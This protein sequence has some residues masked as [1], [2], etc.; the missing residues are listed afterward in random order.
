MTRRCARATASK[1]RSAIP[2]RPRPNTD[3]NCL[4]LWSPA[5]MTL[6][7]HGHWHHGLHVRVISRDSNGI[8]R[9]PSAQRAGTCTPADPPPLRRLDGCR[10]RREGR[11]RGIALTGKA[12]SGQP[13]GHVVE[14]LVDREP[15]RDEPFPADAVDC[16]L[17]VAA[18]RLDA[19]W[20]GVEIS[21]P[22][23]RPPACSARA[24]GRPPRRRAASL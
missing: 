8:T 11:R 24:S 1:A 4:G 18:V 9:R 17:Q 2:R 10:R 20:R 3:R 19:E 15:P 22:P 16:R 7:R 12:A 14:Q 5:T 23:L 21:L 13:A 6:L